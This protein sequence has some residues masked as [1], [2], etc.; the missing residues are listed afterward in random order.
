MNLQKGIL[1]KKLIIVLEGEWL[2]MFVVTVSE[3]F[4]KFAKL[5]FK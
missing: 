3:V 1:K 2:K 4:L 5:L